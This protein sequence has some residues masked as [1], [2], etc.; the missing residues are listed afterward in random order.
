[1]V[2]VADPTSAQVAGLF[3]DVRFSGLDGFQY[4]VERTDDFAGWTNL[5]APTGP[6]SDLALRE[7]VPSNITRC[8][9]RVVTTPR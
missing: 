9:Y 1:M 7:I 6:V 5:G 4:R 8:F 2:D 3:S